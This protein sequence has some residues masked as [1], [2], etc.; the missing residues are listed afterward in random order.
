[1]VEVLVL[2]G[3]SARSNKSM[4]Q[5]GVFVSEK[6]IDLSAPKAQSNGADARTTG[7]QSPAADGRQC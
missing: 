5:S 4:Q 7:E 2:G 1:M 6:A 3:C